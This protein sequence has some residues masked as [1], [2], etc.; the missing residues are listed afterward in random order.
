MLL[1]HLVVLYLC[2]RFENPDNIPSYDAGVKWTAKAL[3]ALAKW[4]TRFP[5]GDTSIVAEAV[6]K[7]PSKGFKE[8]LP[9]TRL[10]VFELLDFLACTYSG[11]IQRDMGASSFVQGI[12]LVAE[13]EKDPRCLKV[14]FQTYQGISQDWTL[15]P[16]SLKLMWDSFSRY[17]PITLKTTDT[18]VPTREELQ[19]LLIGCF[20]SSDGYAVHAF[21][22]LFDGLDTSE[23]TLTN[24]VLETLRACV[25]AYTPKV[26]SQWCSKIW[27]ALK[28]EVW[29]GTKDEYIE[30]TLDVLQAIGEK[31][32][33]GDLNWDE[34]AS[35]FAQYIL[36]AST[37]CSE[38][39]H[40]SKA[41]HVLGSGKIL[42]A[43]ASSSSFG[44]NLVI[45]SVLPK[46]LVIWDDLI[47]K[48]KK[49]ALLSVFSDI[50][51]ARLDLRDGIN[52]ALSQGHNLERYSAKAEATL[53]VS[54][55]AFQQSIVDDVL[56]N[57]MMEL[58]TGDAGVDTPYKVNAIKGL[59]VGARI[60]AFLSDYHR[61]TVI[62]E[63]SKLAADRLQS[64]EIHQ[65]LIQA[66]Q[67]I[68]VEDVDRFRDLTLMT[69]LAQ[70][71]DRLSSSKA[72]LANELNSAAFILESLIQIACTSTCKVELAGPSLHTETD[73]KFRVFE[74]LQEALLKKLHRVLSLP[75]QLQFANAILIAI[76][77]GLYVFDELLSREKAGAK[78]HSSSL[79]ETGPFTWII[80]DLYETYVHQ[81]SHQG[82]PLDGLPYVGLSITLDSESIVNDTFF[83]L[84]SKLT[85]L[86][87]RSSQ[88][89]SANNPVFNAGREGSNQ[90]WNL[91]CLDPTAE[92][93]NTT[94]QNLESG[95]AEKCLMNVL[96][97]S[98]V[99]GLR[100]DEKD[101]MAIEAGNTA[102][103]MIK[104]A[105]SPQQCSP[106]VKVSILNFLQLLINKFGAAKEQIAN[107]DRNLVQIMLDLAAD[108]TSKGESELQ[109]IYQTLAYFTAALLAAGG[110]AVKDLVSQMISGISNPMIGRKVAQSF[111]LLL[112]RSEV[113][114]EQNFCVIRKLRKQHLFFLATDRLIDMWRGSE[115]KEVQENCLIALAGIFAEMDLKVLED[116]AEKIFPLILEG[117]NVSDDYT[118][119]THILLIRTVLI[120]CPNIASTHLDSIINRMTDRTHN[121]YDSPSDASVKCRAAALEV[122]ALLVGHL[123]RGALLRRKAKMMIELDVALD[124]CSRTVRSAAEHTKMRWFNLV[125][126][127]A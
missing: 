95:P 11:V 60:P 32:D 96:S 19:Q 28:F 90:I 123:D 112:A 12:V 37:E 3:Q 119:Y 78:S 115:H 116:N 108:S 79:S 20:A 76:Y 50:L 80:K 70:L 64:A 66:L 25:N 36:T 15:N 51:Q 125:E 92:S 10:A 118:M 107:D 27:D 42:R 81:K 46:M 63:F 33:N 87:L 124:D 4:E 54:L 22:Y 111:R 62:L 47:S 75:D 88:T 49:T 58:G 109:R 73:V 105:I 16:E 97:M 99:A 127:E 65:E 68:A 84:L 53:A 117:T 48:D 83:N 77:R 91:F 35:P 94:Q 89:T 24:T 52:I 106:F 21:P 122:L 56:I 93:L 85:T 71:P 120:A 86:V 1:V 113:M 40:D 98:L 69:F 74:Q 2:V 39:L 23:D 14:L 31:L 114:T 67:Q 17:F 6:F 103:S 102:M 72:E 121:T 104:N 44:F 29:D 45:K 30:R 57:A 110:A 38:R 101:R 55:G 82:G 100:R 7:L 126:H 8:Q 41:Q 9:P 26:V 13:F 18:S 43:I 59:V 34:P 61:G 5:R